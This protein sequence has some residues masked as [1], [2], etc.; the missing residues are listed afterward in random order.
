MLVYSCWHCYNLSRGIR[1]IRFFNSSTKEI[2]IL[3]NIRILRYISLNCLARCIKSMLFSRS[4]AQVRLWKFARW[5]V[6]R[7]ETT[8]GR[9]FTVIR[10]NWP[11]ILKWELKGIRYVSEPVTF[12]TRGRKGT[13]TPLSTSPRLYLL[14]LLSSAIIPESEQHRHPEPLTRF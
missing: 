4:R 3:H 10:K 9:G 8:Q 7:T 13:L 6:Q 1:D 2:A 5:L 12:C 14:R 11:A